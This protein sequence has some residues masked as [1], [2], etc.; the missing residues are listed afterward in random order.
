MHGWNEVL[1]PDNAV[2]DDG[3]W[4]SWRSINSHLERLEIL[5]RFPNA[6]P[7]LVH[8]FEE[9]LALAESY[10]MD[11]GR[12]LQ[13]YGDI[14]ELFCAITLGMRLHRNHAQGSDGRRGND[15]IEVKTIAPFSRSDRVQVKRS[16]HFS[17]LFVVR[18]GEDF[19]VA[20]RMIERR[21]LPATAS[22]IVQISWANL[23]DSQPKSRRK[24]FPCG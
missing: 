19:D 15:F 1:G 11:T 10:H 6:D 13:V 8:Y 22:G 4:V 2:W 24:S 17:H 3:E 21:S 12:H 20:G 5:D 7:A 18:I 16:G 14:G 9:L 23:S